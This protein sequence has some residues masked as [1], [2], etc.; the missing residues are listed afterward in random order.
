MAGISEPTKRDKELVIEAI[1]YANIS[2]YKE[3]ARTQLEWAEKKKFEVMS[4]A[5]FMR[6]KNNNDITAKRYFWEYEQ[7]EL[8]IL[9]GILTHPAFNCC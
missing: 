8:N 7:R 9:N 6:K 3:E 4:L 1:E 2:N 5:Y